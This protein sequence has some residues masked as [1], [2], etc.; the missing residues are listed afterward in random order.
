M[1]TDQETRVQVQIVT[2]NSIKVIDKCIESVLGQTIIPA[3]V[4]IVDNDSDDGCADFMEAKYKDVTIIRNKENLGY[5]GGHNVGFRLAISHAVDYVLTLNPDVEL[6]GTYIECLLKE[7]DKRL[8]IGGAI[9]KLLRRGDGRAINSSV[10]DSTGLYMGSFF[11]VR[12]RGAGQLDGGQYEVTQEV[13]GICGA[14]A[15]YRVSMLTDLMH[16]GNVFDEEFF[17]Y[18]EDVDLC[19]RALRR[20]WKFL[21]IH[22]ALAFHDRGWTKWYKM[23][24]MAIVH[25]FSNQVAMLIRHIPRVSTMLLISVLMELWR[26]AVLWILRPK[27]ARKVAGLVR[28]SWKHH[29]AERTRLREADAVGEETLYDLGYPRN[30]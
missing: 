11:H 18:K 23:D 21:Y 27:S 6:S 17:L 12:D 20:N 22:D 3:Y 4:V 5:A 25:S 9:G 16:L 29:V 1:P 24:Q 8:G 15:F 30:L 2:Y 10:I 14:A 19:W 26:Y 13:W 28:K 7:V